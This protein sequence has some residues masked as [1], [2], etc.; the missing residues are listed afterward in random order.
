MWAKIKQA[1]N[2]FEIPFWVF[3]FVLLRVWIIAMSFALPLIWAWK[4]L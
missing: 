3:M 2:R 1:W 4:H